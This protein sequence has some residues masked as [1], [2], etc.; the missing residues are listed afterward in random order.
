M[1]VNL[2]ECPVFGLVIPDMERGLWRSLSVEV[3]V[4]E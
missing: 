4:F 3:I 2:H 1:K